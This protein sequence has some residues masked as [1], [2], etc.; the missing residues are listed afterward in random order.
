MLS[1]QEELYIL[2]I[3]K[4]FVRSKIVQNNEKQ[5]T[6]QK[7]CISK[8]TIAYIFIYSAVEP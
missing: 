5:F 2:N 4:P 7:V 6:R 3:M 1:V 8:R